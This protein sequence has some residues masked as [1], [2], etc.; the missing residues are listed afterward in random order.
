M[1]P[2]VAMGLPAA[3]FLAVVAVWAP[4]FAPDFAPAPAQAAPEEWMEL[5]ERVMPEA[6]RFT[7]R[8]GQPPVFEA[9]RSDPVTG[10]ETLTGYAFLTADLPPEQKGFTGPIEVLVG[11]DVR[12]VLTGIVVTRY[13]ESHRAT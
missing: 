8:R 9:Y 1:G 10:E 5:L 4:V 6:D 7:A 3:S 2:P 11:M 12:G 13:T